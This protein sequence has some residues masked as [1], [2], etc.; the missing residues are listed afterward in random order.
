MNN[1]IVIY[2]PFVMQQKVI[3][4]D[5]KNNYISTD[6]VEME[7]IPALVET[8]AKN[9]VESVK[10]IGNKDYVFQYQADIVKRIP[11]NVKITIL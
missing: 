7:Q 5:A 10:I 6:N 2:Q 4:R 1:I 8:L 11:S 3:V 9:N